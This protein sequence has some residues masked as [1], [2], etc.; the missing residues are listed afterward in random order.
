MIKKQLL[1]WYGKTGF[2]NA[3]LNQLSYYTMLCYLPIFKKF[4]NFLVLALY[5]YS[6]P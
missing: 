6:V 4:L 3:V 2:L 1:K 5:F